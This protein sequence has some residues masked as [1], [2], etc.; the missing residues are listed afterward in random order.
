MFIGGSGENVSRPPE[1]EVNKHVK[2]GNKAVIPDEDGF[3]RELIINETVQTHE[4]LEVYSVGSFTEL[5]KEKPLYPQTYTGATLNTM[6]D[7]ILHS[8]GWQR[9]ITDYSGTQKITWDRYYSPFEALQLLPT[10]FDIELR[11]RIEQDGPYIYRFVDAIRKRGQNSGKEIVSGKDLLSAERR[12]HT[13]DQV[14]ALLGLA[15]EKEDGTRLAV[16]VTDEDALQVWGRNGRHKWQVYEPESDRQDM[17]IEELERYTRTEL[18]K[19][20]ASAIE[21]KVTALNIAS[22]FG[23]AHEQV[24]LGDTARVKVTDFD[25]PI[26]L[27]SRII[28]IKSPISDRSKKEYTLGEFIEYSE[29]EIE[30]LRQSLLGKIANKSKIVESSNP[31]ADTS[32]T[33]IDGDAIK[34]YNDFTGEW[35]S[36]ADKTG[37]HTSYDTNRVNNVPASKVTGDIQDALNKASDAQSTADG[38]ITSFYQ[39]SEPGTAQE[40]DIWY[41]TNDNNTP[42]VYQSGAWQNA[43]DGGIADALN[44]AGDAQATA[45]KKVQTYFSSTAPTAESVG[46]LW[47]DSTTNELKRWNGSNWTAKVSDITGE[48]T[49]YD[50]YYVDGKSSSMVREEANRGDEARSLFNPDGTLNTST[51]EGTINALQNQIV[52]SGNYANAHEIVGKG[53]LF[54]NNDTESPDYG[55][56]YLGPG[57]L[58]IANSKTNGEWEWS[59]FGTGSGFSADKITAGTMLFNRLMGGEL[60]VGG[61]SNGNGV[62][63]VRDAE[64]E[65][66]AEL[67]AS[68]GGFQEL[69]IGDVLS[70]SVVKTNYDDYTIEINPSNGDLWMDGVNAIPK[71]NEGNVTIKIVGSSGNTSE[72]VLVT[73]FVGGGSI[74]FDI[75]TPRPKIDGSFKVTRNIN[76][77]YV[78]GFD[79]NGTE[80]PCVLTNASA[81]SQLDDIAAYCN[82]Q[83]LAFENQNGAVVFS[84]LQAYDVK[85]CIRSSYASHLTVIACK[86]FGETTGIEARFGGIITGYGTAP[87]SS[88]YPTFEGQ[89]GKILSTFSHDAGSATIPPPPEK[90]K[91]FKAIDA[92]AWRPQGGWAKNQPLQGEWSGYGSYKGLWI[93]SGLG[94]ELQGKTIKRMRIKV[95]REARGGYSSDVTIRF[96]THNYTSIPG[97]EPTLG[98]NVELGNFK[99]GEERWEGIRSSLFS[100]FENGNAEGIGIYGG[101]YAYMSAGAVLEVTYQ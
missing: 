70:S 43:K 38:K 57:W 39:S 68:T 7:A 74:T 10:A 69:R 81:G 96:R 33:W 14:T 77:I 18:N 95:K 11:F 41:D 52:A 62:F 97:G 50:T 28:A 56:L 5:K 83:D 17:T 24:F 29:K 90:T 27:D 44:S 66:V 37:S 19:R 32:A 16:E 78:S 42:Y 49:S 1:K 94:A 64:G 2:A 88:S 58:M 86:G 89:G 100:A 63:V 67:D 3:F 59:T 51:L 93:F 99:W 8:T 4:A 54:E 60:I 23:R 72:N 71:Y 47:Y 35:E 75:Q 84:N 40:G 25:P 101:G 13:K 76:R 91:R 20:K 46:D 55:A 9:G 15:P 36:K 34:R 31:P 73:G 21:Y 85:R 92:G 45:D 30:K 12:E 22:A 61:P 26:Y 65:N 82:G 79:V 98:S 48:H 6:L 53:F 87:D 80:S